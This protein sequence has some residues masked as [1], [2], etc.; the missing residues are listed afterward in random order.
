MHYGFVLIM[1]NEVWD[2]I[3]KQAT[4]MFDKISKDSTN[5][6]SYCSKLSNDDSRIV[7]DPE[8][9]ACQ[10]ITAGLEYIY[11][12]QENGDEAHRKDNREFKQTMLCA[13]LNAYANKL[14][15]EVTSPCTVGEGTITQAFGIGNGKMSAWCKDENKNGPCIECKRAANLECE[16][17]DKKKEE[18]KEKLKT[19]LGND[20]NITQTVTD[21]NNISKNSLCQRA[22][23][24]I[25]Q[26]T[27][28][29]REERKREK[30]GQEKV[31]ESE[32]WNDA[33][34]DV[35]KDLSKAMNNGNETDEEEC[36]SINGESGIPSDAEKKACSYIVKGLKHIYNTQ[37]EGTGRKD[38][39]E[40]NRLF[41]QTMA[42]LILNEYG[43]LL[44]EK[45]C[46]TE[47]T[48]KKAFN[49]GQGIKEKACTE[50]PCEEC[51][52][53]I[54]KDFKI[55][56]T[57]TQRDEIKKKLLEK[58]E[59]QQTFTT[60]HNAS[61]L[62]ERVKCVTEKWFPNRHRQQKDASNWDGSRGYWGDVKKRLN[63]LS[64]AIT[65]KKESVE[66]L[67]E[68]IKDGNSTFVGAS[69][70][71]CAFIVK[72][73][74]HIYKFQ[75]GTATTE[76]MALDN[77]IF[78]RTIYCVLLNAFADELIEKTAGHMCPITE[79][80]ISEMFKKGNDKK[81]NWCKDNKE[82][83]DMKC[84][85]CERVPKLNCDIS[86][87]TNK[88]DVKNK[89]DELFEGNDG[90]QIR[91][92]LSII[93]SLNDTLCA[94][95]NCVTIN[96]FKDRKDGDNKQNWCTYW[97]T[98][99]KKR[100]NELSKAMTET[101]GE[102]EE[103]CGNI[104]TGGATSSDAEKKACKLITAGLKHIYEIRKT[105]VTD[106]GKKP[107][108][109]KKAVHNVQFEQVMKCILLNQ[110][111]NKITQKCPAVQEDKIRE[112]FQKGNEKMSTWC[113]GK[114]PHGTGDCIKCERDIGYK[115]CTLNVSNDLWDEGKSKKCD[116]GKDS[117]GAQIGTKVEKVYKEEEKD[118]AGRPEIN[119]TVEAINTICP[120]PPIDPSEP[121]AAKPAATKPP[122][123]TPESTPSSNGLGRS[124]TS[125]NSP[126]KPATP[127]CDGNEVKGD[128]E[129]AMKCINLDD[130]NN[131]KTC[132]GTDCN[133]KDDI[134][135]KGTFSSTGIAATTNV[136]DA[137]TSV[138]SVSGFLRT[139]LYW[140]SRAP[141][142][143]HRNRH[144]N[145]FRLNSH[146]SSSR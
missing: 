59:I 71:A 79:E 67:C 57:D 63:E 134:L 87:G 146:S 1:N 7:T 105:A 123:T 83:K 35:L 142:S 25:T 145:T 70:Q 64:S 20:A 11:G 122:A 102:E 65:G 37:E 127:K 24:V 143:K 52:W 89:V 73:L 95:A 109:E 139:W 96:W 27:R 56:Q 4:N 81:D 132:V 40:N 21:I 91:D 22:Q 128:A 77:Q 98:D 62:C 84:E 2:D 33:K 29:K 116:I 5:V 101:I 12:I 82:G 31:W 106:S 141:N 115:V 121:Q 30:R 75:K 130:D 85:V 119:K 42:C 111:A 133:L 131:V 118:T 137:T 94:R 112:M 68:N 117:N 23:C 10:Y 34:G 32:A 39:K 136:A 107:K 93:S 26:R 53:D 140:N 120:K 28:E 114:G 46:I 69:K 97:D 104:G 19:M 92:S 60:I 45:S 72:G 88:Y 16:V 90:A 17:G 50:Q 61:S 55:G 66:I 125:Q 48:I 80:I 8:E 110:Y 100:L 126:G 6:P 108:E 113:T 144:S 54:C 138:I 36:K 44:K 78:H 3:K 58:N 135:K 129:A 124:E 15:E 49:V 9:K 38:T 13:V 14:K 99:F 41:K 76:Q 47:D 103:L 43:K 86:G 51:K 18:V 74:E